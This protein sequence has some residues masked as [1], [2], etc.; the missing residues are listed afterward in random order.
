MKWLDIEDE[1]Y[2]ERVPVCGVRTL[3]ATSQF[4]K[5]VSVSGTLGKRSR[6]YH[7]SGE[8]SK[9]EMKTPKEAEFR[10]NSPQN[11]GSGPGL[12]GVHFR[13]RPH[14]SK[15]ALLLKLSVCVSCP[16]RRGEPSQFPFLLF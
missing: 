13:G 14:T 10:E 2:I 6:V 7:G 9:R 4:P 5:Y 12:C 1:I 8:E 15:L 3:S 11:V 16:V